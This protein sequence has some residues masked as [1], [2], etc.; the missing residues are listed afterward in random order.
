MNIQFYSKRDWK[1]GKGISFILT[2]E[3]IKQIENILSTF[4]YS[5]GVKNF[6]PDTQKNTNM[7]LEYEESSKSVIWANKSRQL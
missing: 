2:V 3:L 1:N 7:I 5:F 4:F 6:R